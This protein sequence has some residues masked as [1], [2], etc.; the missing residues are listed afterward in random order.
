M[1][2]LVILGILAATAIPAYRT[3]I[4]RARGAEAGHMLKVITDAEICHYL[5]KGRFYPNNRTYIM[6]DS[7][8]SPGIARKDIYKNLFVNIPKGH[9]LDYTIRAY[10]FGDAFSFCMIVISSRQNSFPLFGN[11]STSIGAWITKD[12]KITVF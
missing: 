6:T 8:D 5:D 2:V 3:F 10:N 9:L 11:G 12:G 4:Y 1:V 7:K